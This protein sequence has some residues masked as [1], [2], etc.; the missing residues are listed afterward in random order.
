MNKPES[1][2]R[3]VAAPMQQTQE[4][5][6]LA[7]RV[8]QLRECSRSEAEQYIEGGWVK[9]DG[10]VVEDPP[11]RVLHQKVEIDPSATLINLT[12]VTLVLHKPAGLS[13]EKA[14]TLLTPANHSAHDESGIRSLKR[15]F[16]GLNS[17]V[18]LENGASGLITF[19]QD[20]RTERKLTEDI[21]SMEHELMV[22]VAG[23]DVSDQVHHITRA[24][25]DPRKPLPATKVSINSTG[26]GRNTLRFA[27]KGAHPGLIAHLCQM[28]GLDI[29]AMRRIRLGRVG[30]RDLAAGQWR[31]LSGH[32]RF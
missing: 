22:D 11:F 32:E 16:S 25:N 31:Y 13:L 27:I 2:V 29:I 30:L 26:E 14:M 21:Q 18:P 3:K 15:H 9:V 17:P 1:R 7:K 5:E 28:V 8:A 23:E 4:G 12:P 19:T 10:V 24:L 6:R 20:W